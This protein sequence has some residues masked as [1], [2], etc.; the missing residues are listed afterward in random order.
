MPGGAPAGSTLRSSRVADI[1]IWVGDLDDVQRLVQVL[2]V[3]PPLAVI[4]P[5]EAA[6]GVVSVPRARVQVLDPPGAG[7]VVH[8][9]GDAVDDRLRAAPNCR[10]RSGD[11]RSQSCTRWS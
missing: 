1:L 8:V 5:F 10:L 6:Q 9:C 2:R 11:L 4:Q 3:L 7:E